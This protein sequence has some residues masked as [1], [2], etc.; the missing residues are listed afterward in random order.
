MANGRI[1][2]KFSMGLSP[3]QLS[4]PLIKGIRPSLEG[5]RVPGQ[6]LTPNFYFPHNF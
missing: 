5:K 6:N 1:K 2:V 3:R 4:P